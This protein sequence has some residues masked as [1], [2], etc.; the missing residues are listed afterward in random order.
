MSTPPIHDSQIDFTSPDALDAQGPGPEQVESARME[1]E[2][3]WQQLQANG[4]Y[5]AIA[6]RSRSKIPPRNARQ[7]VVLVVEDDADL[8]QLL[9]DV[10]MIATFEVRWAS[11]RSE[12]NAE[13]RRGAEVDVVLLD[14]EL[15][16]ANGL[17]VL[18]RIREHPE[19]AR[20]PV[21]MMTGKAAASDIQA[22]LTARADGYVT[23]PFKISGLMKA[24][25][26]VLGNA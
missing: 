4:S 8:A 1:A 12:I 25:N 5:V 16:D 24:V 23:K 9:I 19:F 17:Q 2:V 3:G 7:F 14:I 13:L 18:R 21:I 26:L 6:R 22:G 11:N 15:P 20:L 10:F